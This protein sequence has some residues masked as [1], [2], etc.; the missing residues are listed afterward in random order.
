MLRRRILASAMASVMAIGSVAVVASAEDTAA[1]TAQVKTKADLEAYVK[2]FDS[3]RENEIYDYG[4][5]SAERFLNALEYADNVLADASA[6]VD[7]YTVAYKMVESVYNKL[8]IYTAEELKALMDSCTKIYE[9]D[10]ILNEELGD[11]I[12]TEDSF[13][14]FADAYIDAESYVNSNDSRLVTDTYEK[15][16]EAKAGLSA[17][18]SVT[19]SQFRTA[20]KNYE[21]II[22][23]TKAYDSWRR[24][25]STGWYDTATGGYWALAN[26][27]SY[28]TYEELLD[29]VQGS[30]AYNFGWWGQVVVDGATDVQYGADEITY[31]T[32]VYES[33]NNAYD[34]LDAVK[35]VN[36]TTNEAYV[37]AYRAAVD[38]VE[39]FKLWEADNTTRATKSSVQKL[40]DTYHPQLVAK[41][42][43]TAAE[44]LYQVVNPG[45][46][47]PD[48]TDADNN[49][50][51]AAL[52]NETAK[53][54]IAV[55][56]NG[57]YD[58]AGTKTASVAKNVSLLKYIQVTSADV[59]DDDLAK[60]M[61]YAEQY[62]DGAYNDDV[63]GLDEIGAVSKG[64][65]SVTEWTILYRALKYALE[66]TFGGSAITTYTKAQVVT[67]IGEAYD[68]A[69]ETGDAAIFNENHMALVEARQAALNWVRDANADKSYKDG[70]EVDGKTATDVYNTL[71][72]AYKNLSDQLAKYKYS[73]G[74]VYNYISDVADQIDSGDLKA[75]DDL[76]AALADTAYYLS[77]LEKTED[78]NEAFTSDRVFLEYN[79][80]HTDADTQSDQELA[81]Q[82]AYEALVAA[83]KAQLE[84]DV[85]LGDVNKDGVVNALD[86]SEILKAVVNNT[87]IDKAVG[88]YNAD[89]AVNAL[90]AAA[91]LKFVVSQ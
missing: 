82:K 45:K 59:T 78:D 30:G 5:V 39:V 41:Y 86:A 91:I 20:L 34:E 52:T 31:T 29:V 19:K 22:S 40:L 74:E 11:L 1:A 10:N 67:L 76:T 25:K 87:E 85:K 49:Y 83:V 64:S 43:T 12:Y 15:L 3:F 65:G 53:T 60:V 18:A 89:G 8:K 35:T 57:Y 26:N 4:S 72:T 58:E 79:R 9:S 27:A 23:K 16:T 61:D 21:S 80:V 63:F 73:Y 13:S 24:G 14:V 90:D 54:T 6:S 38:A 17:L 51:A 42:A 62:I 48:W 28:V 47:I 75:T 2:S 56:E 70:N 66:D 68:L 46:D 50:Y 55:D 77:I 88:D 33:I 84:P 36:K 44:E 69:E 37:A 81:L 7:E 71:Y 32:S